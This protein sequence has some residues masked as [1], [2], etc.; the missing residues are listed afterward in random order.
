[1]FSRRILTQIGFLP[2]KEG[3]VVH[4]IIW[5]DPLTNFVVFATGLTGPG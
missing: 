5:L 2:Q 3:T 1:M 4:G